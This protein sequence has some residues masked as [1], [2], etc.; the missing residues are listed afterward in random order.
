MN[1]P[2]RATALALSL[3]TLQISLPGCFGKWA[4]TT[5]LYG[6]NASIGDR[7]LRSIVTFVF[8][9]IPVYGFCG[10]ID[11]VIFNTIEFWSGSN[12]IASSTTQTAADGS[13]VRLS[14]SDDGSELRV[15]LANPGKLPGVLVLK[16]DG[17]NAQLRD[18]AGALVASLE[19][20]ADGSSS[21]RAADGK[22]LDEKSA[23]QRESLA[24]ALRAG[25]DAV[26]AEL[27]L[28]SGRRVATAR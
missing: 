21:V 16:M 13:A 14:L 17:D 6:V 18:G 22:L 7:W 28:Q 11:W 1:K 26:V 25:G 5:K 19:T 10:L 27:E 3:L 12:P 23:G 2:L 24:S 9:V 15:E 20:Q 8:V 4:L